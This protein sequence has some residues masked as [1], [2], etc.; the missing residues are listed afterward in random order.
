M[1]T[2]LPL[3]SILLIFILVLPSAATPVA[4]PRTAKT[5]HKTTDHKNYCTF[6]SPSYKKN[7]T[8]PHQHYA[9]Y[10]KSSSAGP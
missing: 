5:T 7:R 2:L 4:H 8:N 9:P 1:K 6:S 10:S 3:L